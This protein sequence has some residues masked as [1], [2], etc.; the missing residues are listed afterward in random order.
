M[1]RSNFVTAR[2]Q[3]SLADRPPFKLS[4]QEGPLIS[5]HQTTS[6]ASEM[7]WEVLYC[8]FGSGAK[9]NGT[10]YCIFQFAH[11][12]RPIMRKESIPDPRRH[13]LDLAAALLILI[14]ERRDK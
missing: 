6:R 2:L 3:H 9:G 13:S 7:R 10:F 12:S 14:D 5:R 8:Q 1:G 4:K 11:V